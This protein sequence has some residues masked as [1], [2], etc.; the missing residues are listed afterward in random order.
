L[1]SL[2]SFAVTTVANPIAGFTAFAQIIRDY[3]VAAAVENGVTSLGKLGDATK[4]KGDVDLE[5]GAN[6]TIVR[7]AQKLTISSLGGGTTDHAALSHLD[8]ASAGHTGFQ[9]AGSYEV[10]G[11]VAAHEGSYDHALL[12]SSD[13]KAALAGTDGTPDAGN[14]YVTDSDPRLAAGVAQMWS[15]SLTRL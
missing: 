5:E 8:Y 1:S 10:G 6:V 7:G 4:L 13:E 9:P 15:R 12:P 11:A 2:L 14:P 3:V